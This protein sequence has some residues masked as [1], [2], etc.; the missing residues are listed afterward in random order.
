MD[1]EELLKSNRPPKKDEIT[2]ED[3]ARLFMKYKGLLKQWERDK[4]FSA[5]THK[6]IRIA[7][8]KVDELVEERTAELRKTNEQLKQAEAR[9]RH[10]NLVLRAIRNVNQLIIKEKDR[11]RLLK[12]ACANLIKTRG[13]YN[14]WLTVWDESGGLVTTAE[15][16]LGEDFLSMV[17]Q[18]KHGKL[19]TCCQQA[20]RQTAVVTI[21]DPLSTCGDCPL[22]EKHQ[23]GGTLAIRLEHNNK[24]YGLLVTSVP[25]AF[26]GD[27]EEHSLLQE[28]AGDIAFA[29]HD[30]ELE[31]A[32]Q[33]A[34]RAVAEARAYAEGIVETVREPLVVLDA[35]LRVIS[36]NPSFYRTFKIT[37]EESEGRLIYEL[38]NRQWD[39]AG[40]RE[41]L[42]QILPQNTKFDDFE[43]EHDFPAIGRKVMLLN[44]RRIYRE[45]NKT[46]MILLAIEDITKRKQAEEALR[47]SEDKY[48]TIF[49][50]T[51]TA[52]VI[53]EED[54]TI[55]LAN[56]EF[57]K[58]SGYSKEE[59]ECKKS[60]TEFVAKD[61]LERMKEYH[62]LRRIDPDAAPK[63]YEFRFI[64]R[65]GN[66][67][68]ILLTT[69][70]IPETK[71]SVA[72]L[73]DITRRK[74]AEKKAREIET[75]KEIDR[76]RSGLLAN[77][78]HELRTPLTSIKGFASTLLD[79]EVKW[80]E[81]EQ[82]D[83][84]Q[85]I[86]QESDR[87]IRLIS[88][89]LDMSRLEASALKLERAKY[90]VS[91]ILD[92]INDGLTKLTEHHQLKV[93]VPAELPPVSVDQM[94]IGQVLTNLV[95]NATKF[96]PQGSEI[97]I[98]AKL[99]S[100]GGQII[101]S[102]ADR[103]QGIAPELLDKVFDRFYQAESIVS[104]RKSG[105][106]LGLSICRGI[107]EA[108]GEKIWAESKVGEG[109]K[110]SFS[111]PV[112]KGNEENA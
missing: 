81:E 103:G 80:S 6:N 55:S 97:T 27:E 108:H 4:A 56:S 7:Y 74:E 90:Q 88:D 14:A 53:I 13:Y 10:L 30:M 96:S 70:I 28:V 64:D 101:V 66:V 44:A 57:E 2:D 71:K 83:F 35:E 60:W 21:K 19:S 105:T 31:E 32:R 22:R 12:D 5:A 93:I 77:V 87:L 8:A 67:K 3:L 54:T 39:I 59:L 29:L 48:R 58:L 25:A 78:S 76:L 43:V 61:D 52:T 9:L 91:K 109:S 24:V 37:P 99:E 36:A 51:G 26:A 100:A 45:A 75:L 34:E 63:Q 46:Q 1:L 82:R 84:L 17:E 89:L 16:G 106:G 65:K 86:D 62:R 73:L 110:F 38:D 102:V 94:R 11:D 107:M 40:L 47:E 69:D 98:E 33:R 92:S 111:L 15:A 20:L 79:P 42:E 104:G 85:T 49:E 50:T 41:L 68:D 23:R 72:S 95:E 112:S 18:L